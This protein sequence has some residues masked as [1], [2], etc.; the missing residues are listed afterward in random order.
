[1][2][3]QDKFFKNDVIRPFEKEN[4]CKIKLV[5]FEN[6]W[7]LVTFLELENNKDKKSI[8]LVKTPFEMT[9]VLVGKQL[10]MPIEGIVDSLTL[11]NA[12]AEYHPLAL[13]LGIVDGKMYYFPRKLETRI[14][15]YLKSRVEEAISGW[16]KY[17]NDLNLLLKSQNGYGLPKGYE[18]EVD[19]NKWDYYDILV[20]GYYWKNEEYFGIKLPRIAHR[21]KAYAGTSLG[22]ID[23]SFSLGGKKEDILSMAGEPVLSMFEWES[24]YIKNGIYN[25]GMWEDPWA[26]AGLWN[27]FKD[28]K[29]FLTPEF[30]QIDCFFVHGWVDNPE[31]QGYLKDPDDMGLA[32]V[33]T[34]VS[35][36][37]NEQGEPVYLGSKTISTGGWWW[38]I[39]KDCPD[40]KLV[41]KLIRWITSHEVQAKECSKFGMLPVRKDILNNLLDVFEVGWVGDVFRIS[42]YQIEKN[43]YMTIPLVKEYDDIAKNYIAAWQELCVN[44]NFGKNDEVQRGILS[45]NLQKFVDKQREILG[46]GYPSP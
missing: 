20:V 3:G 43:Q 11:D 4:G 12:M 28:G 39:P 21:G 45:S 46:K 38:G 17:E 18:L 7:D 13:A 29:I 37:L 1:M 31:M 36:H 35:W 22:L 34:G 30:Q 5:T 33:P 27:A 15:F 40:P 26:G 19:P 16:K 6:E 44:R 10:L 8:G 14:M 2:P 23:K 24:Y 32:M 25:P 42:L 9:R 41:Y